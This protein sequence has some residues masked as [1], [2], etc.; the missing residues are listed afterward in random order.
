MLRKLQAI[1]KIIIADQYKVY[2][3]R[4]NRA[5][6]DSEYMDADY[7]SW[8]Y[9]DSTRAVDRFMKDLKD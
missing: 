2:T 9:S 7:A 5:N 8:I 1:W 6:M 4:F 3:Y